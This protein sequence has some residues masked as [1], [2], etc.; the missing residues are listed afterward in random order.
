MKVLLTGSSGWLGRFLAPLLAAHGHDVVGLDVAPGPATRLIGSVADRGF[1]DLAFAQER[2][3]AVIHSGAL[4]QPDIGRFPDQAFID[5]NVGGTLNL[6][7]AA[8]AAGHDRFVLTSTTSLMI[9]AAIHRGDGQ[10]ARWIDEQFAPLEPRNIYGVTKIAAEQLCRL[11]HADKGLSV[12]I[13]RTSRF[14]GADEGGEGGLN[15]DNVR[16]NELLHRRL[17]VEDA[18]MA[19]LV[20]L[21][22]APEVGF[23]TYIVSAPTPF[24]RHEAEALKADAAAVIAGHFPGVEALYARRGWQLPG[25]IGRVYDSSLIERELGFR[26]RTDFAALLDA[27]EGGGPLPFAHDPAMLAPLASE[28]LSS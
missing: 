6:L 20:A 16:A 15:P 2:P 5:T 4:H 7:E 10:G 3:D 12:V 19:H 9:N 28:G 23:G 24:A 21:E 25:A 22:K 8:S 26:C 17:T 27:L 14:F 1:V 13:L 11:A 18:A